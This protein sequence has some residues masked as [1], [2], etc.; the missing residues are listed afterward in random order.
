MPLLNTFGGSSSRNYGAKLTKLFTVVNTDNPT[1]LAGQSYS[2]TP[3]QASKG[4][5]GFVYSISP[6]LPTGL[7]LNT[8]TGLISGTPTQL[9][10]ATVYTITVRD[11]CGAT[12]QQTFTL[13]VYTLTEATISPAVGGDTNID[14]TV[15]TL[16]SCGTWTVTPQSDFYANVKMWGAGGGASQDYPPGAGGSLGIGGA[17][18]YTRGNVQFLSGVAY[19]FT[20]GCAGGGF[21]AQRGG[22]GGGGA[23]AIRIVSGSVPILVAGGGGGSGFSGT[24]TIYGGNGGGSSASPGS[25]N[26]GGGGGTQSAAGAGGVGSRRTGFPGSGS[27]GGR[28]ANIGSGGGGGGGSAY[29]TGGGGNG[30]VTVPGGTDAGSGGGGGG[31]FGGGGGGGNADGS[32]GG[33]GSS[34]YNPTYVLSATLTTGAGGDS[35]RGTAASGGTNGGAGGAGRIKMTTNPI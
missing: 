19:Q 26:A 12:A 28:G 31:Y 11:R 30:E 34:Y 8:S 29:G 21:A 2:A 33:G 35:D 27:N 17:G 20:V 23:T 24:Q 4:C 6:T 10:T 18:G 3:L 7:S 14:L 32:G 5:G 15:L 9:K 25:G 1:I 13:T 16:P 22:G